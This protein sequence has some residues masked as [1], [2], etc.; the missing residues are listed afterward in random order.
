MGI[1]QNMARKLLYFPQMNGIGKL[2]PGGRT[3]PVADQVCP[4]TTLRFWK[5]IHPV[6]MPVVLNDKPAKPIASLH[7]KPF[8][9]VP[10]P[11][12]SVLVVED[13][14]I[15]RL[16]TLRMLQ[17]FGHTADA[18]HN[19]EECLEAL[20]GKPYDLVLMDLQMPVM[21]GL[22]AAREIRRRQRTQTAAP[23]PYICALTANVMA[24]DRAGCQA[25]GMD[26]FITKPMHLKDLEKVVTRLAENQSAAPQ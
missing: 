10:A 13:N 22:T 11:P 24:K 6:K 21:D 26:D 14:R 1:F 19:G 15:N 9:P 4:S 17:H 7:P 23:T 20:A 18:V 12:L 25:A 2:E 3:E 5:P 8:A 16:M